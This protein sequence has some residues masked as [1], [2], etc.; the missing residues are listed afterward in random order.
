M[1]S[2]L[3]CSVL[4]A[5]LLYSTGCGCTF[6]FTPAPKAL[7]KVQNEAGVLRPKIAEGQRIALDPLCVLQGPY[8]EESRK[9]RRTAYAWDDWVKHRSPDRFF[10][11]LGT[12]IQSGLLRSVLK[13][14]SVVAAIATVCVL[15][16]CALV[17]GWSDFAG[18]HHGPLFPLAEGRASTDIPRLSLPLTPFTL[19]SS[20]LG[21]LL[22]FRTNSAYNR[23]DEA[24]KAWGLTINHTRNLVRMCTAW[25]SAEIE[26]DENKRRE[27]LARVA[28]ST[29]AFARS[30]MRHISN[31]E[32]EEAYCREVRAR[33]PPAQAEGL[34]AAVHRPNRAMLD[35]SVAVNALPMHFMRKNEIDKDIMLFGDTC[36]SNERLFS[37]PVP[38][39]YTRHTARFLSTWLLL[40]PLGLWE[41]F[42]GTWNHIGMIPGAALISLFL[43]GIEELAIELEEPFSV[44]PLQGF[45]DKIGTNC[46]EIATWHSGRAKYSE[47]A[48]SEADM[49]Q[50]LRKM[51]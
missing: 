9:Y 4:V 21:L 48:P 22:V 33:L 37:S 20:A 45:C 51:P 17:D 25:T 16:N 29:W 3:R 49:I 12:M 32:D 31:P 18:G 10:Y 34:I 47:G 1:A 43:F 28:R 36:G 42:K 5:A 44:L 14:V 6:A 13:E 26:P 2:S 39:F 35:L 8:G 27:A 23:W 41:P 15:W 19:S 7:G 40:L 24:R 38:L 11:N 30:Q 46:D 50:A